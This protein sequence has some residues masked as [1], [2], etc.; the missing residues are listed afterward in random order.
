MTATDAARRAKTTCPAREDCQRA[1]E[2]DSLEAALGDLPTRPAHVLDFFR[3]AIR[4]QID[5]FAR[6]VALSEGA[7]CCA[8][9]DIPDMKRALAEDDLGGVLD[10]ALE[11]SQALSACSNRCPGLPQTLTL[12]ALLRGTL[13]I[14]RPET[15][16]GAP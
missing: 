3:P 16:N 13:E 8:A 10:S 9:L 12:V 11:A 5:L 15:Q 6:A 2:C 4:R 14:R 1:A 7:A